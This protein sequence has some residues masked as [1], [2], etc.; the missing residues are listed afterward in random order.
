VAILPRPSSRR[1]QASWL[2]ASVGGL[3]ELFLRF[4]RARGT[5][6]DPNVLGAFLLLPGL[7]L[8][9]RMLAGRGPQALW[10]G[11]LLTIIMGGLFLSFSRAAWGSLY[12]APR[13]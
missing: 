4:G 5:F 3:S 8:V 1:R 11:M 12:C 13:S 9:Q 7:L 6:N 10:A 2:S